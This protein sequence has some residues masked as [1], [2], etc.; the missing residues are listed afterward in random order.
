[1]IPFV[2]VGNGAGFKMGRSLEYKLTPHNRLW[3]A[4]AHAYGH[5][6]RTFGNRDYCGDGPLTNLV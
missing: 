5:E 6:I 1:N 3:M 2:L 4:L